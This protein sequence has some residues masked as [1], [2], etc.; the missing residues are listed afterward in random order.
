MFDLRL[1]FALVISIYIY[2]NDYHHFLELNHRT[3][4]AM[5]HSYVKTV[6]LFIA[7]IHCG[8]WHA[9]ASDE[10]NSMCFLVWWCERIVLVTATFQPTVAL[11]WH[12]KT[13][14]R[15]VAQLDFAVNS[16]CPN[17]GSWKTCFRRA[18]ICSLE[19]W[20]LKCST[21]I[22]SINC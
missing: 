3:K 10:L 1:E 20:S 18:T 14:K 2:I 21:M 19:S 15:H 7:Q 11:L 17:P 4:W 22:R 5:F 13:G 16:K 6:V 12:P 9:H 8:S